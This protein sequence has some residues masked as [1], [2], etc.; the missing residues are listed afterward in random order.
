MAIQAF[1]GVECLLNCSRVIVDEA[2]E[3]QKLI[4]QKHATKT[5]QE[6]RAKRIPGAVHTLTLQHSCRHCEH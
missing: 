3:S 4:S 2:I 1:W 5:R 6:E